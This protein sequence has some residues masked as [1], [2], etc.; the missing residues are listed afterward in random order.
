MLQMR[1]SLWACHSEDQLLSNQSRDYKGRSLCGQKS[2]SF[3]MSWSDDG[4]H[5]GFPGV[6]VEKEQVH[7]SAQNDSL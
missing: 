3:L 6:W 7:P 5:F 1:L 2:N 4:S